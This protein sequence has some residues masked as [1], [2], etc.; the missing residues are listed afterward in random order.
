MAQCRH[1]GQQRAPAL[2]SFSLIL[3]ILHRP[4]IGSTQVSDIITM[5]YFNKEMSGKRLVKMAIAFYLTIWINE[6]YYYIFGSLLI[7][8]NYFSHLKLKQNKLSFQWLT[9]LRKIDLKISSNHPI[10]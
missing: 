4:H 6:T 3:G 5:G 8:A 2:L 7:D 9:E 1:T 10:H